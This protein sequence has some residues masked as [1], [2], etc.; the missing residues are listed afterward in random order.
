MGEKEEEEA[1]RGMIHMTR[2]GGK[3]SCTRCC[4]ME[5]SNAGQKMTR[6]SMKCENRGK[7]KKAPSRKG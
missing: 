6:G 2:Y 5:G 7:S 1:R 3:Y 4:V